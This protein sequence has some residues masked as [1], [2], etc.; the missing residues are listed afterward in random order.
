MFS[1]MC[2]KLKLVLG[3]GPGQLKANVME[4]DKSRRR[5]RK[6]RTRS[7]PLMG[8]DIIK[9]IPEEKKEER[10]MAEEDITEVAELENP[11]NIQHNFEKT[12]NTTKVK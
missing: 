7:L 8:T 3:G 1:Y 9:V 6:R 11:M 12:E 2:N 10:D 4:Q 5:R